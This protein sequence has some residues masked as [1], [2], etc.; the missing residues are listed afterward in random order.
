M[1]AHLRHRLQPR[2]AH[3]KITHLVIQQRHR[4]CDGR[5]DGE[6]IAVHHDRGV[7]RREGG[8]DV[9]ERHDD[10]VRREHVR[11]LRGGASERA[12]RADA[13]RAAHG[14]THG[15]FGRDEG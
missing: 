9:R 6:E 2:G 15:E 3:G 11:D 13:A 14:E 1:R 5:N 8:S 4:L 10:A 12:H 7:E